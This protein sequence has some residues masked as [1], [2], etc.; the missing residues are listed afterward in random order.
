MFREKRPRRWHGPLLSLLLFVFLDFTVGTLLFRFAPYK[1]DNRTYRQQSQI[2]GHDLKPNTV[3]WAGWGKTHYRIH[4]NS[5]GFKDYA[6]RDV[7]LACDA[8]RVVLLGDSFTE[9][10]GIAYEDTFAGILHAHLAPRCIEVLNAGVASY[11]PSIYYRKLKYLIEEVKLQVDEVIVFMDISDI[12]NEALLYAFSEDGRVVYQPPSPERPMRG[13]TPMTVMEKA[14]ILL[15]KHFFSVRVADRLKDRFFADQVQQP[16]KNGA[17]P[18]GPWREVLKKDYGNWTHDAHAFAAYGEKGLARAAH[19]MELLRD[20]VRKHA[21]RLT[22]VVYPWP[23]QIAAGDRDSRQV[24]FWRAWTAANGADFIDL[25]G[26]F[27]AG[28]DPAASIRNYYIEGDIHFNAAGH[29]MV[30]EAMLQRYQWKAGH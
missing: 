3:A 23:N 17:D 6:V 26:D 4:T 2:Y 18:L 1:I 20:L 12:H 13:P 21:V 16:V 29:Q 30:A 22:V 8:R 9:G 19:S 15:R 7:P 10:V 5:L 27:F 24:Q 25:F 14:K 11:S 28:G